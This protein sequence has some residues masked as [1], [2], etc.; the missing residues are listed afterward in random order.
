MGGSFASIFDI[1]VAVA[2]ALTGGAPVGGAYIPG[3]S[4]LVA[5]ACA[6][7]NANQGALSEVDLLYAIACNTSTTPSAAN[8][9]TYNKIGLLNQI[10]CNVGGNY[11]GD[12]EWLLWESIYCGITGTPVTPPLAPDNLVATP[13]DTIVDL[14]WDASA[15]ATSYA[16]FRG[17]VN[18]GPYSPIASGLVVTN[19]HDTGR[20]NGVTYYYVVKAGNAGGASPN[21]N[22]ASATPNNPTDAFITSL[23]VFSPDVLLVG[24]KV[25]TASVTT[26][27][28]SSGN[29]ANATPALAVATAPT[30]N[31]SSVNGHN[32]VLFNGTTDELEGSYINATAISTVVAVFRNTAPANGPTYIT[33]AAATGGAD[34]TAGQPVL[35]YNGGAA[36]TTNAYVGSPGGSASSV[37]NAFRLGIGITDGAFSNVTDDG[38]T[39]TPLPYLGPMATTLY[40]LGNPSSIVGGRAFTGDL[41]FIMLFKAD[42]T[43]DV[44][45]FSALINTYYGI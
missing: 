25:T 22:Q 35:L 15:T 44:A 1:Q 14:T 41:A 10:S 34:A 18:G 37:A 7:G 27:P 19:Y 33:T 45:A 6:T 42:K 16:V 32:S 43:A 26:W 38:A 21:S 9:Y 3:T 4:I 20:T 39:I 5:I 28:D 8:Y 40:C 13:G 2:C 36:P 30:R 24:D 23:L 11:S 12:S 17:T 31:V 29:A